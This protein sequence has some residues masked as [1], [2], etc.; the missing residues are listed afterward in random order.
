ML[1]GLGLSLFAGSGAVAVALLR[2]ARPHAAMVLGIVALLVG[3]GLTLLA[4][5]ESSAVILFAGAAI[6]GIGYGAGFHG[7]V[8]SVAPLAAPHE[9][10]GVLAVIYL[11]SYLAMSLP[12]VV[13]G[14]LVVHGGGVLTT[15]REYG[16]A[17]MALG[18]LAL[19]GMVWRRGERVA[20]T[21]V[22]S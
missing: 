3:V 21:A 12:A 9:R 19:L 8:R 16:A 4:I 20:D 1:G 18:T 7:V 2:T 14:I 10:A 11:V 5:A 15:A 13:G 6:A 17:V 22:S